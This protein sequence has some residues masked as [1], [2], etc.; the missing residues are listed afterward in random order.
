MGLKRINSADLASQLRRV[1]RTIVKKPVRAVS[2]QE[3]CGKNI[4]MSIPHSLR[5]LC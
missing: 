1:F 5:N 4:I 2:V 3:I